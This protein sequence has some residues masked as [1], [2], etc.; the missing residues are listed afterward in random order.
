MS[1]HYHQIGTFL[2]AYEGRRG[3]S[4]H[5]GFFFFGWLTTMETL[6]RNVLHR[7]F[8]GSPIWNKPKNAIRCDLR[9]D[10]FSRIVSSCNWKQASIIVLYGKSR[11]SFLFSNENWSSNPRSRPTH[12]DRIE[13]FCKCGRTHDT[14][15][16]P[17]RAMCP[18]NS[19]FNGFFG[20]LWERN[21]LV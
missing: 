21:P 20:W 2:K 5:L 13:V 6:F 15:V 12:K 8:K 11:G 3:G 1:K 7:I 9:C 10:L 19:L 4:C 14:M 17:K 18:S 16:S